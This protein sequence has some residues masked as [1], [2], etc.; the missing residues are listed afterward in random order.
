[1]GRHGPSRGENPPF[2]AALFLAVAWFA[3]WR[4]QRSALWALLV[5][6]LIAIM[7]MYPGQGAPITTVVTGL[8]PFLIVPLV[9]FAAGLVGPKRSVPG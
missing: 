7:A 5:G 8:V 2:E 4:G 1:M 9:A 6:A 3:F